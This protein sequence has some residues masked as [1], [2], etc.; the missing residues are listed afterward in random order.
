MGHWLSGKYSTD[1]EDL[2]GEE[3]NQPTPRPEREEEPAD[4]KE[5]V[6]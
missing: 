6:P 3:V 5:E 2:D 1:Y 4:N